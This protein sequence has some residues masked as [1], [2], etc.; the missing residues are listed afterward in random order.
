MKLRTIVCNLL[1]FKK[2]LVMKNAKKLKN[3]NTFKV[4]DFCPEM[5]EYCKQFWEEVKELH[6]KR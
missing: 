3:M 2:K 6:R 1:S 4:G 5:M